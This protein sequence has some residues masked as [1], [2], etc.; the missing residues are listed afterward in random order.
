MIS[1][2]RLDKATCEKHLDALLDVQTDVA[3]WTAQNMLLDLPQKWELSIVGFAPKP[4]CY[5]ILST[6][7]KD[8]VHI[9][10]FMVHRS[11]RN[12]GT[13]AKLLAKAKLQAFSCRDLLS[14]NVMKS[15]KRA[16]MFYKRQGFALEKEERLQVWLIL[17][18]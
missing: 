16:L 9:H 3:D 13:G 18:K 1:F 5:A 12:Q 2:G 15:N 7:W 6:K 11:Y 4:V 14:L 10:H 8:R 17:H